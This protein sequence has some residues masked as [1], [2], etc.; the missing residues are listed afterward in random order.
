LSKIFFAEW[1]G[2][3]KVFFPGKFMLFAG[4]EEQKPEDKREPNVH[5]HV[6]QELF[7]SV[8]TT[9]RGC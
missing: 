4:L 6:R 5:E 7:F 9:S 8:L 3:R 2:Y 1:I